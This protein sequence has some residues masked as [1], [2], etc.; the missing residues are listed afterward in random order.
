[1]NKDV[2]LAAGI[3]GT[4]ALMYGFF[5]M[6][7]QRQGETVRIAV[8]GDTYG[9]YSLQE[10]KE[11]L[12]QSERGRNKVIIREGQVSMEFADCPD[13]YCVKHHAIHARGETIVCLP[14]RVVV[15]IS[16]DGETD[17]EIDGIAQ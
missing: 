15:E 9:V 11:V 10:D 8:D 16:S 4:A 7:P 6:I 5:S 13:Q 12:I 17:T 2:V 3:L 1:M 14:H